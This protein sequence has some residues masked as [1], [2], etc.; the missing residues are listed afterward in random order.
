MG[1]E[2]FQEYRAQLTKRENGGGNDGE[3]DPNFWLNK[4]RN[5]NLYEGNWYEDNASFLKGAFPRMYH[6]DKDDYP[7]L[8]LSKAG[9]MA[10]AMSQ[11]YG[12][13]GPIRMTSGERLGYDQWRVMK[14]YQYPQDMHL[15]N[16]QFQ[17]IV[18]DTI[19]EYG[20]DNPASDN[21]IINWVEEQYKKYETGAISMKQ[22][23]QLVGSHITGDA[24]DFTH[25]YRTWL[26]SSKSKDFRKQFNVKPL[27][28]HDHFHVPFHDIDPTTLPENM[29]GHY[30]WYSDMFDE[31]SHETD[32]GELRI[33]MNP[34]D[35]TK[36]QLSG[37]R[38]LKTLPVE[39]L[40]LPT[41][42]TDP[43][44]LPTRATPYEIAY[45]EK[46]P[47]R[48]IFRKIRNMDFN[49]FRRNKEYG[50][51]TNEW[52]EN[53]RA[54]S[55]QYINPEMDQKALA[56]NVNAIKPR[57]TLVMGNVSS[58]LENGGNPS[59]MWPP[60][61]EDLDPNWVNPVIPQD[62]VTAVTVDTDGW[63]DLDFYRS[64]KEDGQF[65]MN[66]QNYLIDQGFDL[67]SDGT[68]GN[69][70]YKNINK[71]LVNQQLD[72]YKYTNFSESQFLDQIYKESA[73]RNDRVS[74]KGA[75]GISQFMPDTFQWM[76]DK[77]WIPATARITDPAA[78]S[79]AQRKY[80]D[81]IYEDR[82]NV[83]SAGTDKEERQV[84]AFAAYN[85][86]PGGFDKFWNNLDAEDKKAGWETWYTK[87]NKETKFYIMWMFDKETYKD[88][89][90]DAYHDVSWKYESW[91]KNN[92]IYR[93]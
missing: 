50:G 49:I 41:F 12:Y 29:Q 84:R 16:R 36:D 63:A 80:M 57:R 31:L 86:G 30:N 51:S 22:L 4:E 42:G 6:T 37:V 72:N 3:N 13:T 45:P 19:K 39:Q 62:D 38:K 28:E 59:I 67:A 75:M 1:R 9:F 11:F 20:Y 32:R 52:L 7:N 70:T 35:Y 47:D 26:S 93:Y 17:Q 64:K 56:A 2:L 8:N 89:H 79:L 69:E 88:D 92:P 65:I 71:H 43:H 77:G 87:L 60:N 66:T 5:K 14:Q 58:G 81:Y 44:Q 46:K 53:S 18:K 23:K 34:H 15:Y 24:G 25:N 10:V 61:P 73:G 85:M 48:N 91:K 27:N 76:K 90:P 40:S 54:L 82:D 83:K 68:W 33:S 55:E 21:I 74:P 78:Q